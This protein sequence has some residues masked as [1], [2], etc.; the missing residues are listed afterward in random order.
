M[1]KVS[2]L[3]CCVLLRVIVDYALWENGT[4]RETGGEEGYYDYEEGVGIGCVL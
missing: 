3:P 1:F 4:R 2:V